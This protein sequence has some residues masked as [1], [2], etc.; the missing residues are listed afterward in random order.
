MREERGQIAG[1]L[2]VSEPLELWGNVGGNVTVKE[3]GKF[4]LRG[5][6]LGNLIVQFG[7]RVHIFG[8]VHGNV[9]IFDNTKL[10]HS[11]MIGGDL[12]NDGGRLFI[13]RVSRVD[14]RVKT[15]SGETKVESLAPP[16]PDDDPPRKRPR[17]R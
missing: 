11:G 15:R 3:G 14:G 13:E 2:V 4:Y 5:S 12:I 1:D 16:P 17:N 7:G 8:Q 10:I 9:L 6:V